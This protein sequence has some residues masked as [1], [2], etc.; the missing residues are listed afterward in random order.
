MQGLVLD[1][2]RKSMVRD[3]DGGRIS[4][5]S[6]QRTPNFTSTFTYFKESYKDYLQKQEERKREV[7]ISSKSF[8]TMLKLRLL[9]IDYVNIEGK[10][11]SLPAELKWLQ[12]KGCNLR[13]LP[14]DF[15]PQGLSVLDLSH[16]KIERV[17]KSNKVLFTYLFHY[18]YHRIYC[19]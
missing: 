15:G 3:P 16:S 19:C 8:G 14:S 7:V 12:W 9:Q 4:W 11:K 1:I 13:H 18:S 10:L 17:W 2:K 6:L 5:E